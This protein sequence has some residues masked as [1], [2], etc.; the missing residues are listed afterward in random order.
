M[1]INK[2]E[3]I[4]EYFIDHADDELIFLNLHSLFN[5]LTEEEISHLYFVY[6]K[7]NPDLKKT[8]ES[9]ILKRT[10]K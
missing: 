2:L 4:N 3:F 6:A 9:Y 5:C 10:T 8:L 1:D 7:S